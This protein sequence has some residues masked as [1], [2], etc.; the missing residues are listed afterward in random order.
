MA[1]R[2]NNINNTSPYVSALKNEKNNIPTSDFDYSRAHHGNMNIGTL[3]ILDCFPTL[4]KGQ[5]TLSMD[6]LLKV[7]VAM[8]KR[9]MTGQRVFVHA[10]YMSY[11]D[12]WEGAQNHIDHG[13]SGLLD[14]NK[15]FTT[16][17]IQGYNPSSPDDK[18]DV[19]DTITP[20]SVLNQIGLPARIMKIDTD[21]PA[22]NSYCPI[23]NTSSATA[24]QY[25]KTKIN[26]L[27]SVMYQRLYL[28]KYAPKN[29]LQDNKNAY[30]DNAEKIRIPYNTTE[31]N[32]LTDTNGDVLSFI[33][34]TLPDSQNKLK[35]DLKNPNS[36]LYILNNETDY[37]PKVFINLKRY[38][39]KKGDYFVTSSPFADLLRGD[40][41]TI[42]LA[43]FSA[44]VDF[45]DVI[46]NSGVDL[47]ALSPNSHASLGTGNNILINTTNTTDTQTEFRNRI[48]TQLNKAKVS[49]NV[50]T[51][52]TANMLRTLI[53]WTLIKERNALTNGDYNEMVKAQF[54]YSPNVDDYSAKYIGGFYQDISFSDVTQTSITE[55]TSPLGNQAGQAM[56]ANS[57]FIGKFTAPDYGY[58]MIIA[59]IVPDEIYN[60]GIPRFLG[61]L[62]SDEEYTSPIQNNLPPQ[63]IKNKEIFLTNNE[64][65]NEDVLSYTQR[66]EHLRHRENYA[67]G[68][69]GLDSTLAAEDSSYIQHKRLQSLPQFNAKFVDL[70][71]DN[72]DM[73]P[74]AVVNE[75]PY[76]F[77]AISNVDK[78]EPLPYDS[79][80]SDFGFKYA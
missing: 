20:N 24:I 9:I 2:Y 70:C 80:P 67:S 43:G 10:W 41:P 66:Y 6:L 45:S 35:T 44:N 18:Y 79:I 7:R 46:G 64:T 56:S 75:P 51:Q 36:S 12:L 76:I 78:I 32:H 60:Q 72:V 71:P 17:Y 55:S 52:A 38:R 37:S 49:G 59:S 25:F 26:A 73:S 57:G 50:Q 27:T 28:D 11:N 15:P 1:D 62:S 4:P 68:F 47:Q 21:N 16:G 14:I 22:I 40:A 33:N 48:I 54:G 42:D 63:P 29:L 34:V 8:K 65:T 61:E 13:R 58:I 39:Q 23:E 77:T 30:P 31:I 69:V 5:Y 53:A 74:Y 3:E 19:M